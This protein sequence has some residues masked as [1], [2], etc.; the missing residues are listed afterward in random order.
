MRWMKAGLH[1]FVDRLGRF[2]ESNGLPRMAGRVL[3]HFLTSED[4]EQTFDDLVA[5]I[6]ASRS[7][8]SVATRLLIQLDLV[9]RFGIPGERK[10]RYRIRADAWTRLLEQD[11]AAATQLRALAEE[12]LELVSAKA[13]RARLR[14]MREFFV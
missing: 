5:A 13:T 6:G 11:I 12:G 10:D 4:A 3:G 1:A 9:E 8:V 7:S 14:E 2:F